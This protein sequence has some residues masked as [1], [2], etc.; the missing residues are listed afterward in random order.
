MLKGRDDQGSH[1]AIVHHAQVKLIDNL[2]PATIAIK[3]PKLTQLA[4][5]DVRLLINYDPRGKAAATEFE[6]VANHMRTAFSVPEHREYLRSSYPSEP[7]L[8]EAAARQM[9]Q[10]RQHDI[11]SGSAQVLKT[12]MM[13][14]LLDQGERGELVA[15]L[16]LVS[17]YDQAI[18]DEYGKENGR[19]HY[20]K[21]CKL[22]SFLRAL[23]SEEYIEL[24][25]DCQPD[26][27]ASQ[28]SLRV[29]F[30]NAMVRFTHFGR[31]AHRDIISSKAMAPAYIRSMAIITQVGET[32]VDF[33]IPVLL[34]DE[35]TLIGEP[36]MTAIA[37]QVK[38]RIASDARTKLAVDLPTLHFFPR[39]KESG[40]CGRPYISLGMELG[41][42]LPAHSAKRT[43]SPSPAFIIRPGFGKQQH[44]PDS[45]THIRYNIV[46]YGC[47][48]AV[49][50]A[51]LLHEKPDYDFLLATHGFLGEHARQTPKTLEAVRRQK[52][53]W[54]PGSAS[55]HWYMEEEL[56]NE[57]PDEMERREGVIC[58]PNA[59]G[60]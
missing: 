7:I 21:G 15:R 19:P 60:E 1:S 8:A 25:L 28:H 23:F 40:T 35:D 50:K 10:F 43:G 42:Q 18:E 41:V 22:E 52:P 24:I 59:D 14:G 33:L 37:I 57:D 2:D 29:A 47:S 48:N 6:L 3:L 31:A 26:I 9:W 58:G 27:G 12:H 17:A 44:T 45:R 11:L 5:L 20:S 51:I 13:S 49:Y 56:Q 16:L 34:G 54:A 4:V 32:V 36:A 30:K 38:R 46:A 55:Y 39:T 53:F